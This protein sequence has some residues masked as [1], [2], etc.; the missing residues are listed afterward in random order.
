M[1]NPFEYTGCENTERCMLPSI[2]YYLRSILP[3]AF[4]NSVGYVFKKA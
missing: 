2:N 4:L 1:T 3:I